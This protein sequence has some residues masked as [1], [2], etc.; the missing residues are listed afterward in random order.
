MARRGP[1]LSAFHDRLAATLAVIIPLAAVPMASNR[2]SIWLLWT[3]LFAGMAAVV[4]LHSPR[5]RPGWRP[6]FTEQ[7]L[8]LFLALIL[9]LWAAIQLIPFPA[10]DGS[11]APLS[12]LP[13][14][15]PSGILRFFGYLFLAAMVIEIASRRTRV[16][17]TATIIFAGVVLQAVWAL[18]A[19]HLL[20]DFSLWGP[21]TAYEG[22][23]TGTFINRNSLATFLALGLVLGAG[24]L[25]ERAAPDGIRTAR[26][27]RTLTSRLGIKGLLLLVGMGFIL[28]ALVATQSRLGLVA[29]LVGLGVTVLLI[30]R[31]SGLSAVRIGAETAGLLMAAAAVAALLGGG[32]SDR[33]I[34]LF[35][36]GE[37]RLTIYRQTLDLIAQRPF[38]GH[39]MDAFGTAFEGVRAPPLDAPV[40]Y[41]LAH[42]SYLMLWSEFGLI[43]GSAPLLALLVVA[44]R[45]LRRMGDDRGFPGIAIGAL[46]GLA[47]AAVHSLGDFSLEVPANTYLFTAMLA[48]G[49]GRR[50]HSPST[51]NAAPRT[52]PVAKARRAG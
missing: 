23:A 26:P 49:L 11:A 21:K 52:L 4:L 43:A 18:V 28:M 48:L 35:S 16:L 7:R 31:A 32:L 30:R 15:G 17:S 1:P 25:A 27:G 12:V 38:A 8:P 47:V 34:F 37:S 40:T 13:L 5:L 39:G 42:N 20:D 44:V 36:D 2:A 10:E 14:A 6:R 51:E 22:V 29:A 41:D 3:A 9:P 50:N 24:L 45:L 46:G 19:L 33:L